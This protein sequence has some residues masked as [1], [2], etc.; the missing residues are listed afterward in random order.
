MLAAAGTLNSNRPAGS[1]AQELKMVE[2]R[3]NGPEAGGDPRA[4]PNR[5]P[6]RSVYLPL[7][8]GC[9][10]ARAGGV[11]PGRADAG[12]RQP[13]RDHG[14]RPGAVSCSTSPFVRRQALALADR[15][16]KLKDAAD[17]ERITMAYRLTLGRAPTEKEVERAQAFL[18]DYEAAY[19]ELAAAT[20]AA[21][22]GRRPRSRRSRPRSRQP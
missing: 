14:A 22:A 17:N 5:A 4:E 9:D 8:R 18:A 20:A 10:A 11:R 3:D 6:Y 12:H 21:E 15:L 19:R 2:M 13:R 16:L 1:P 7:L